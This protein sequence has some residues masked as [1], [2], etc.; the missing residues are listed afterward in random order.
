MVGKKWVH[1]SK[2]VAV[3][4]QTAL[5]ICRTW[6]SSLVACS[7]KIKVEDQKETPWSSLLLLVFELEI[8][9][10]RG[11]VTV[12]A[13]AFFENGEDQKRTVEN[14]VEPGRN[15][16]FSKFAELLLY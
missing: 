9:C 8:A 3:A 6:R 12:V 15:A 16:I 5:S 1:H 11:E 14:S 7:C 13:S 10:Y 4:I 2:R